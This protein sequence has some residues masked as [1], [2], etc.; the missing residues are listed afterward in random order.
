[1]S[2]AVY[3]MMVYIHY[4]VLILVILFICSLKNKFIC[5][6]TSDLVH[7][8]LIVYLILKVNISHVIIKQ[9]IVL[10]ESSVSLL[11]E[12]IN[13][14]RFCCQKYTIQ[15]IYSHH[16][17]I[18]GTNTMRGGI[19]GLLFRLSVCLY[20]WLNICTAISLFLFWCM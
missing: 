13:K 10:D 18:I 12:F 1:M 17:I 8:Y 5:S 20:V 16:T 2:Q 3:P 19:I 6:H 4:V 15:E 11:N 9:L 7:G 14:K